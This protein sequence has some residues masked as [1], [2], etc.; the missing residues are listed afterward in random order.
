MPL[1][2][3]RGTL[4]GEGEIGSL[5]AIIDNL[6]QIYFP[7]LFTVFK[8]KESSHSTKNDREPRG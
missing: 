4:T 8:K 2:S 5:R 7:K 6:L 1:T 3:C